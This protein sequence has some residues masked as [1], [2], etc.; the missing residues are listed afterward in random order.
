M[1]RIKKYLLFLLFLFIFIACGTKTD[2]DEMKDLK[3]LYSGVPNPASVY[4]KELGYKNEI[5]SDSAG[6][7]FEVC[8]FPDGSECRA[9]DFLRGKCGQRF[10]LC[11][12]KGGKIKTKI[13][14]MGTWRMEYAVC[15][16]PDGSE[17]LEWKL[18]RSK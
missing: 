4:C 5:R 13:K 14:D 18:F 1:N 17:I 7:Q 12:K 9:W 8:I 16:F 6:S 3:N 10:S 11:E 15:V 2:K